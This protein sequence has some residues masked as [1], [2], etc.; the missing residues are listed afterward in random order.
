MRSQKAF[1]LPDRAFIRDWKER[2]DLD[3]WRVGEVGRK[4]LGERMH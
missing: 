3:V 2:Q 4:S 1:E